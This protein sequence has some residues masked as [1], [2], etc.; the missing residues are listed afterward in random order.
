MGRGIRSPAG[1]RGRR[2]HHRPP[3]NSNSDVILQ[4]E[5]AGGDGEDG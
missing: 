1:T 2:E 3:K 5:I 4:L